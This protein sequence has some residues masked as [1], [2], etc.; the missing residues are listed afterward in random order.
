VNHEVSSGII[1]EAKRVGASLI[2]LEDLTDIRDNI[3]AVRRMRSR[4]HRWSF[5]QL[6]EFVSYKAA[7]AGIEVKY[8]NPAYTSLSCSNCQSLGERKKHQFKCSNCGLLAHADCNASRNLARI[9]VPTD[10]ARA[11]VN[12]PNVGTLCAL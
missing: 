1:A 6:Q 10:I 3:R 5:R 8:V 7:S 12:Q 11:D 2:V 4:L 9:A